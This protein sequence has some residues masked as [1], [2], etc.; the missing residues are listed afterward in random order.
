M[1]ACCQG[2][3]HGLGQSR[4][5]FKKTPAI[6]TR[7]LAGRILAQS[8]RAAAR[9]ASVSLS[10]ASIRAN[11]VHPFGGRQAAWTVDKSSLWTRGLGPHASVCSPKRPPAASGCTIQAPDRCDK[12]PPDAPPHRSGCCTPTPRSISVSKSSS[13]RFA[14][15][16]QNLEREQKSRLSSTGP[17]RSCPKGPG[18]RAGL[19]VATVKDSASRPSGARCFGCDWSQETARS[20]LSGAS[21]AATALSACL[22]I[23]LA[24]HRPPVRQRRRFIGGSSTHGFLEDRP[25]AGLARV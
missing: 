21:S 24:W 11:L 10:P 13:G 17:M 1:A 14:L 23:L 25:C 19:F 5:R 22:G 2:F 7:L 20:H 3:P 9:A 18:R 16:R 15:G 4:L 12:A 6:K 8:S